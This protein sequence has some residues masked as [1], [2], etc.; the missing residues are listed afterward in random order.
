MITI[1]QSDGTDVEI[2]VEQLQQLHGNEPI[3]QK[4]T[5]QKRRPEK[6]SCSICDGLHVFVSRRH[7]SD[8]KK[9]YFWKYMRDRWYPAHTFDYDS[10]RWRIQQLR[11]TGFHFP[12][13]MKNDVITV[14]LR[15][16]TRDPEGCFECGTVYNKDSFEV[17]DTAIIGIPRVIMRLPFTTMR[18]PFGEFTKEILPT[19]GCTHYK[20]NWYK[21]GVNKALRLAKDFKLACDC[22][23]RTETRRY[24]YSHI[25]QPFG[26]CNNCF[27]NDPI[28]ERFEGTRTEFHF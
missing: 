15:Y 16:L 13:R 26:L 11:D 8:C 10:N 2:T 27:S 7:C 12:F 22:N 25:R 23:P 9:H 21:D 24:E 5:F 14:N 18:V 4:P 20:F 1:R 6:H 19:R 3:T 17:Y 28:R